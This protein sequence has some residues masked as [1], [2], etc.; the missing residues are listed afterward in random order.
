MENQILDI[1]LKMQKMQDDIL[2]YQREIRQDIAEMLEIQIKDKKELDAK[3]EYIKERFNSQHSEIM[4]LNYK[5]HL[6]KTLD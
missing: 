3:F 1:L 6:L 5:L 4:D 2:I